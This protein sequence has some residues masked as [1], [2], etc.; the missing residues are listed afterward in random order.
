MQNW[1]TLSRETI[2]DKNPHLV[3]ESHSIQLPDGQI[4]ED[5]TWVITPD[6]VLVAAITDDNRYICFRQTKYAVKGTTLATVGGYIEKGEEPLSAAK[7]ELLEETGYK[8]G[9]WEHLG[10]FVVNGNRGDGIGH[11]FLARAAHKTTEINSDDL[12]EQQ[13]LLL[14]R[15]EAEAAVLRGAFK[16]MAA[17]A[18]MALTLLKW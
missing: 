9:T 14:S 1:K 8:A 11:F 13:L 2:L 3:V 5:W 7:R 10:E 18:I 4:I 15:A 16:L 6:Y 12:E 17:E